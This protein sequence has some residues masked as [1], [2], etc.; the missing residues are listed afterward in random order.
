MSSG[1]R[2]DG[3]E[4]RW[5]NEEVQESIRRERLVRKEERRQE[6]KEMQCKVKREVATVN[7]KRTMRLM[8]GWSLRKEKGISIGW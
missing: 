4:T 3:K 5:G 8:R 2:T 1:Q 6:Y 7:R